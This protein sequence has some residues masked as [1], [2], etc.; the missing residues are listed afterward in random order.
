MKPK[1]ISLIRHEAIRA[2][3][4]SDRT[5]DQ[6]IFFS[7]L[8]GSRIPRQC[9]GGRDST[10]GF[11]K[12]RPPRELGLASRRADP[13]SGIVNIN[14]HLSK[15]IT[16]ESDH[17]TRF[18]RHRRNLS[19]RPVLSSLED[20]ALLSAVMPHHLQALR[21]SG[22]IHVENHR[23]HK[24]NHS[25]AGPPI[26]LINQVSAGG[27]TFLNFDGP[28]SGTNAGAGTN[29]NGISNSG[30]SVGVAIGNDGQFHNFVVN[31]LKS[32]FATVLNINGST[33]A[34]AFGAN[35]GGTV[36]GTDGNGNAFTLRHGK[37]NTFIPTGGMSATAFGI[38]DKG[39]IVGQ[40]VTA[41]ATPGF[42]KNGRSY[43]TI[44]APSGPNVV[45]AQ[46]INNKG[47]VVGFY[48]GT[49]TQVH[50]F[51]ANQKVAKNGAITGVAIADP[52]IPNVPGEPGATF[53]FSQILGINDHGIAVG[54]Y[55]DSTTSQHGFLLNTR[56][57]QYTFLDDPSEAFN[58]G[59]E[60]TQITGI[61]NSGEITGFYSDANGVFHGFVAIA[62][63]A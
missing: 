28:N 58:N 13:R 63:R 4:L 7:V 42:I 31:P 60:V 14:D 37:L 19:L 51:M 6:L 17:M 50:G 45:N 22:Q 2:I 39:T 34:M 54:Y 48:V 38:N 30:S 49:D 25:P 29:M 46:G 9:T 24:P 35:S 53:V 62:P 1:R 44:N 26:T 3:R 10:P 23:N 57:G 47:L 20:R 21:A 27:F 32:R 56:T 41:N 16:K 40:F 52:T 59:V 8:S 61:T 55:G 33:T 43:I 18:D 11:D 15:T 36:V 12:N 5:S